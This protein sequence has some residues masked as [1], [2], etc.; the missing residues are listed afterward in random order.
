MKKLIAIL[1]L[2]A[3]IISLAACGGDSLG[4]SSGIS[5]DT[6]E[7]EKTN[8]SNGTNES[9][10]INESGEAGADDS[11][12]SSDGD[13][14]ESSDDTQDND[15]SIGDDISQGDSENS[16]VSGDDGEKT[17]EILKSRFPEKDAVGYKTFYTKESALNAW[18]CYTNPTY[19]ITAIFDGSVTRFFDAIDGDYFHAEHGE[20]TIYCCN[21]FYNVEDKGEGMLLSFHFDKETGDFDHVEKVY[22]GHGTG[23]EYNYYSPITM[24]TYSYTGDE[25]GGVLY[26]CEGLFICRNM[27]SSYDLADAYL[28]GEFDISKIQTS[29][30]GLTKDGQI[31]IPF[32]YD[33]MAFFSSN[34]YENMPSDVGV[35]VAEKDGR[36]YYFSTNGTNLTPDGFDCG[37]EPCGDRAW[38]FEDG[39]GRIIRFY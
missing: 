29:K 8:E 2:S 13:S 10:E 23:F 28:N 17:L 19:E 33:N 36:F 26:E 30:F 14:Y 27:T 31:V 37:S 32:E 39:H 21:G 22:H 35:V 11:S 16:D 24:K 1:I 15:S 6:N 12:E 20:W 4:A 3:L 34:W 25:Q 7:S 18:R 5:G 38:V 9:S